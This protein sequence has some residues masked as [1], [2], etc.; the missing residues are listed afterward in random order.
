[1]KSLLS[2]LAVPL[3]KMGGRVTGRGHFTYK[4]LEACHPESSWI[5]AMMLECNIQSS[6]SHD[7]DGVQYEIQA[8][9]S[10]EM[11]LEALKQ[12]VY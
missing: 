1:M 12:H 7:L 11:E 9:D 10:A 4:L 3:Y 2:K 5:C 8:T 6:L